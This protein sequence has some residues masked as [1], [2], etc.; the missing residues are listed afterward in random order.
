MDNVELL[1][2]TLLFKGISREELD[3]TTGLFQ[4]RQ[5]KPNTTLFAEKM[6]AESLYIIKSGHVRITIMAGEGEEKSLLLLGPGEFFGELAL[7]QEESRMVSA[8]SETPVELL[9]LS[10]QDFLALIDLDPRTAS[11]VLSGIARL[12]AMRVK[13]YGSLFKDLLLG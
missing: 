8:R 7:L 3:V 4:E 12:L 5:L 6:P 9:V 10:R 2:K 1:Q 13:A 11:R